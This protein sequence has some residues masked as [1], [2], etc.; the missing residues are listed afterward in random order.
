MIAYL[1][2]EVGDAVSQSALRRFCENSVANMEWIEGHGVHF[3]AR[4]YPQK[5]SYPS[6]NYD[7]YHSGSEL[8]RWRHARPVP[9]GH[10]GLKMP[11]HC[12]KVG[13]SPNIYAPLA[14]SARAAGAR[15][16][17]QTQA[18]Q[19]I[20]DKKGRILGV[21]ARRIPPASWTSF[22]HR[23]WSQRT[24]M[25]HP[26]SKTARKRCI[27]QEKEDAQPFCVRARR[28]VILAT[29]GFITNSHMVA[30]HAGSIYNKGYG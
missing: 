23:F 1:S 14:Q 21:L 8:A 19:L 2:L 16:F 22:W 10:K 3:G 13:K 29:G 28:G 11:N 27:R 30:A 15:V 24:S 18:L 25:F 6:K 26:L 12:G 20:S 17:T 9:R 5:T 7:L 4:Y